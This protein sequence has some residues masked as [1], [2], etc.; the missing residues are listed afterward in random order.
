MYH[1]GF[2]RLNINI[3][4]GFLFLFLCSKYIWFGYITLGLCASVASRLAASGCKLQHYSLM[5]R[6]CND[7]G[8]RGS[9]IGGGNRVRQ[10]CG[11]SL[12]VC[13]FFFFS[14]PTHTHQPPCRA[15]QMYTQTMCERAYELWECMSHVGVSVGG[16]GETHCI[17]L[18]EVCRDSGL[19][20]YDFEGFAPCYCVTQCICITEQHFEGQSACS[21]GHVK[22]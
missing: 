17:K 6:W 8:S 11:I 5:C 20:A 4:N 22:G 16:V 3:V 21:C 19:N 9:V 1:G 18:I 15:A 2:S 12:C 10:D 14:T 7:F 13:F